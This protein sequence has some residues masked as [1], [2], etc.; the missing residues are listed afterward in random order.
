MPEALSLRCICSR[1][2][3]GNP[4]RCGEQGA[5]ELGVDALLVW[6]VQSQPGSL[7]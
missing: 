6:N 4:N 5:W 7:T 1:A 2:A 3:L